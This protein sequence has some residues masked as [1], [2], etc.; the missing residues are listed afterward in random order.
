MAERDEREGRG[1]GQERDWQDAGSGLREAWRE[2]RGQDG[3]G[4]DTDW[5]SGGRNA[6]PSGR[7]PG[8]AGDYS[9]ISG[10][11][12]GVGAV[13]G[14]RGYGTSGSGTGTGYPGGF[15]ADSRYGDDEQGRELW[16]ERQEEGPH[17]G[18]GPQGYKR[19]DERINEDVCDVLTRHGQVDASD[20]IVRVEDGEVTLEGVVNSRQEKRLAVH[21]IEDLPGVKDV[22][23]RLHVAGSLGGNDSSQATQSRGAEAAGQRLGGTTGSQGLD[24]GGAQ[25]ANEASR[26]SQS[27]GE[28][29]GRS[30]KGTGTT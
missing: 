13:V 27:S 29:P 4:V 23:N 19:S 15:G 17:A 24:M 8:F 9:G 25:T 10:Y 22:H 20:I 28:G 5:R 16:S 3:Y 1:R 26:A 12:S 14:G 2:L 7:G 21:A 18:R 6:R 11:G 30:R